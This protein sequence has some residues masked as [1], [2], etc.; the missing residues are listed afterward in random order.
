MKAFTRLHLWFVLTE[1]LDY[2]NV[3]LYDSSMAEWAESEQPMSTVP[4][5]KS[6]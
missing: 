6:E 4:K 5:S 3:R 2:K 1:L